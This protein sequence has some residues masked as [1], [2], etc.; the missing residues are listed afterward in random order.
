M[1]DH[2]STHI[3]LARY[4][5]NGAER[6]KRPKKFQSTYRSRGMSDQSAAVDELREFQ[7]TY[8]SRGMSQIRN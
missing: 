6:P 1:A 3:P 8:R 2:I 4:D 7:S 5:E